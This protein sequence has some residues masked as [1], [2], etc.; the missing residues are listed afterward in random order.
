MSDD[1]LWV[2]DYIPGFYISSGDKFENLV[3]MIETISK[4]IDSGKYKNVA[5]ERDESCEPESANLYFACLRPETQKEKNK[6]TKE[7]EK[8]KAAKD[9]DKK[10]KEERERK[11]YERLKKKFGA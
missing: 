3:T 8:I 4:L 5:L 7:L 9:N 2:G 11:Q 10:K 6:R 1:I